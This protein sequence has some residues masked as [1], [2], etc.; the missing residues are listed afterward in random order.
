MRV[1]ESTNKILESKKID[2]E[3]I[4]R[5]MSFNQSEWVVESSYSN[6]YC[7]SLIMN[8]NQ[9]DSPL[10]LIPTLENFDATYG[11]KLSIFSNKTV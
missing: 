3:Q 7:A 6:H 8:F 1:L 5:K 11:Y 9:I 2:Y 10:L 4:S